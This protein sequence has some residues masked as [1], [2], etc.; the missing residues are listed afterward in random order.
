AARSAGTQ[1]VS[2]FNRINPVNALSAAGGT[3]TGTVAATPSAIAS[4]L[5]NPAG[6]VLQATT[7]G[8][9]SAVSSAGNQAANGSSA[10]GGASGATETRVAPL[11]ILAPLIPST[12]STTPLSAVASVAPL[13][14][15][16]H[17]GESEL[18]RLTLLIIGLY[19]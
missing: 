19:F 9:A 7:R 1:V 4:L 11:S 18:K 5:Q 12:I 10:S 16:Q 3:L 13:L 8:G 15:V 6:F 14:G 2:L 17:Q